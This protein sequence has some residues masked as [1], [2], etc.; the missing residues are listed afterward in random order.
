VKQQIYT[1]LHLPFHLCLA[2]TLEGLRTWTV[3]ANI[4][5]NFGKIYGYID[6]VIG[7]M[8]NVYRLGEIDATT[9]AEVVKVLNDTI[10]GF[11]FEDA[12]TW[13]Y[14]QSTLKSLQLGWA[15]DAATLATP[16]P[17]ATGPQNKSAVLKYYFTEFS[18]LV[19]NEQLMANSMKVPEVQIK[20][21]NGSGV[22]MMEAYFR[23]FK[24][25][26][27]YFFICASMVVLLLGVFRSMSIGRRDRYDGVMITVRFAMGLMLAFL[28]LLGLMDEHI[29]S[30]MSSNVLLPTLLFVL[31]FSKFFTT[32]FDMDCTNVS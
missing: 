8:P 10:I 20:A 21:A 22:A 17:G 3:V 27:I 1:M 31:I 9:G 15:D 19:Q 28:A 29:Q 14:M 30:Y 25:I 11:G 32:R 4:Q 16:I 24:M 5:Y 7:Q 2:L 13:K 18:S 23:V 12:K 26:F 6:K